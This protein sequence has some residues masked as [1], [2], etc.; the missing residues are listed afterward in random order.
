MH[1][2]VSTNNVLETY[3]SLCR[4]SE[5]NRKIKLPVLRMKLKNQTFPKPDIAKKFRSNIFAR[6]IACKTTSKE[7]K[8]VACTFLHD[9]SSWES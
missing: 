7:L 3:K 5:I 4:Q 2:K 8:Y 1:I 9:N 6:Y